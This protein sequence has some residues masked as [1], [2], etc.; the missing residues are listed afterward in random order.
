MF[1]TRVRSLPRLALAASALALAGA[2][3]SAQEQQS[4]ALV[5]ELLACRAIASDTD[6][7]ACM[8]RTSAALDTAMSAGE[9]TVLERARA[10]AA[11]R[12]TFGTAVAGAGRMFGSLFA[13]SSALPAEQA[14]DDGAVAVRTESGDIQALLGVPVRAIR[15]DPLGKLVVTLADGQVWRQT[16]ARRIPVPR[17]TEGL[18]VEIERGA[19]SSHFMRL[20]THPVRFRAARD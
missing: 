4:S 2:G 17:N 7:L 3:A 10:A 13:G 20:S 11:E 12:S 19:M 8:D 6:R 5:D 15:T 18:T 9:L 16:D 14:Y 1:D